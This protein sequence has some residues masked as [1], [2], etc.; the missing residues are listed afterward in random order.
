[1]SNISKEIS[2]FKK[3]ILHLVYFW[4]KDFS[5]KIDE[6]FQTSYTR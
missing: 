3:L 2:G 6:P 5:L 1:M 4:W